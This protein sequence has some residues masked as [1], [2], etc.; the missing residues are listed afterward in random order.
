MRALLTAIGLGVAALGGAAFGVGWHGGRDALVQAGAAVIVAALATLGAAA[1]LQTWRDERSRGREVKQRETY[2]ELVFQLFSR[3]DPNG[4][5]D[6]FKEARLRADA[7][8]WAS[9]RVVRSLA[10]WI[11]AYDRIVPPDA[12]GEFEINGAQRDMMRRA[13]AKVAVA[14]RGELTINGGATVDDLI[15]ALF[16]QSRA[17]PKPDA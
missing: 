14:I 15:E 7:A 11:E 3:F 10:D 2:A 9:P 4:T 17:L 13:T 5:Y 12:V 1:G 8:T 6:R 16:N